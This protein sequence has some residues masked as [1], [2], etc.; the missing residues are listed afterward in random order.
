MP[1]LPKF[2]PLFV[3]AALAAL[4]AVPA[5]A[6]ATLAYTKN[7]YHQHVYVAANDGKGAKEIGPGFNPR[8]SPN[9]DLVAFEREGKGHA[10]EMKLYDVTT[11]KT[12]TI[13]SPWRE[14]FTFAWSPD[15]TMVA[16][17]RGGELGSRSLYVVDVE[18]GKLTKIAT[19]YFNGVSF[20][21]DSKEL[22]FG[23]AQSQAYPAKTDIIRGSVEGGPTSPLTHD[24]I[25]AWPLWGPHDQIVFAKQLNA[26]QRKYGPKNDLFLMNPDGKA[27]KRLTHTKVDQLT[28]GLFPTAWSESGNQ[29]LTEYQGQ[30]TSYAVTVNP[31]TGAEKNLSP[32]NSET[33]FV[34]VA[35][36]PDGK[37]VLGYLGGYEGPGSKLRVVSVPYKG[38]KAK[39]LVKG[40]FAPSWGG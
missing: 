11:G 35:L 15:S 18:T 26:K 6:Q 40:G 34:G 2:R 30:D 36:T 32:G 31:K 1:T 8:V 23:L 13:F 17:L 7:I 39:V 20:S 9:G 27:V 5:A 21:P 22:V 25:S 10:P 24:N 19:G 29:L 28:V 4:L 38:G 16:A 33:G 14:S 3:L 37:T 12:K